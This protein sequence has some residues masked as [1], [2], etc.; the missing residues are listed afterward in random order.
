M[1]RALCA[2]GV[3]VGVAVMFGSEDL[4]LFSGTPVR[5]IAPGF[6]PAPATRQLAMAACRACLDTGQILSRHGGRPHAV[7]CFCAEGSPP[8]ESPAEGVPSEAGEASGA[9][10]LSETQAPRAADSGRD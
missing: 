6:R 10:L 2:V 4:P 7:P 8:R 5:A 9:Y 1:L 3:A